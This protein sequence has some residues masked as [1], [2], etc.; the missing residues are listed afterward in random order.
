VDLL[1]MGYRGP[2][3][4]AGFGKPF[5]LSPATLRDRWRE[6]SEA[7]ERAVELVRRLPQDEAPGLRVHRLA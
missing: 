3:E 4:D 6:G 1:Y 7:A 2:E 5:D